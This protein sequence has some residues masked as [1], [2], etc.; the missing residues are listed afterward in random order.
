MMTVSAMTSEFAR[1]LTHFALGLGQHCA[2]FLG[3]GDFIRRPRLGETV[4]KIFET[5]RSN[6]AALPAQYD[7][8]NR[9][10]ETRN[11]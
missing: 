3:F 1:N 6:R 11:L 5:V 4:L 10:V 9:T 8:A 7:E 2:I